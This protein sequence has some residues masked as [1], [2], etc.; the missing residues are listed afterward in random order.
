YVRVGR[1]GPYLERTLADG[2]AQR[3]NL[4]EAVP[5]DE[6]TAQGAEKLFAT[7]LEGR[8]LGTDPDTGHEVVAKEGRF[9]PYVSELLP[10]GDKSKPRTGSLFKSMTLDTIGL[11]DALRL[12]SLPRVVGTDP[13]TDEEITAQNGR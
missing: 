2:S 10:E 1:Y 6:L 5:P 12:L 11:A 13:D 8:S 7:P 3:A 4:P 9:G